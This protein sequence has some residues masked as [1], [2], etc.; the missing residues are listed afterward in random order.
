VGGAHVTTLLR[1]GSPLISAL[2]RVARWD[3]RGI[4]YATWRVEPGW[5]EMWRGFRLIWVVEPALQDTGPVWVSDTANELRRRASA[6]LPVTTYEQLVDEAGVP[7]S[8]TALQTIIQ[9][10]YGEP[11]RLL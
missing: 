4:A 7:V 9:R 2:E 6:L 11:L 10:D 1:P 3:D 5:P 8:D